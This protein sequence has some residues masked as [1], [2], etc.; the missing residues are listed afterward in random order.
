M[1]PCICLPVP[2]PKY[3]HG[4][5]QHWR[6]KLRG[7]RPMRTPTLQLQRPPSW[8]S[9]TE[10]SHG[11]CNKLGQTCNGHRASAR[12]LSASYWQLGRCRRRPRKHAKKP[13]L[14]SRRRTHSRYHVPRERRQPLPLQ[15]GHQRRRQL[16]SGRNSC[17]TIRDRQNKPRSQQPSDCGTRL[18]H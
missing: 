15:R 3:R 12:Q 5:K 4:G 11:S 14:R 9:K 18:A 13:T 17:R 16:P 7:R 10:K 6:C 2:E 8:P 1:A